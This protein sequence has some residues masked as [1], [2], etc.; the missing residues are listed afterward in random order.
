[1]EKY[2]KQT[3]VDGETPVDAEHLNHIE[4]GVERLSEAIAKN[5]THKINNNVKTV[6]HRGFNGVAPENTIPAYIMS[7][8][9][10]YDYV[11][12]D[13]AFTSDG[14]AVLLHDA[15]IDRTSNGS[16]SIAEMTYAEAAQYDYGSWKSPEFEGTHLPTFREF[17][18]LCKNL[19]LHPYIELKSDGGYTQENIT[20]IVDEVKAC[21]MVGKVTYISFNGTYLGYVKTA[22]ANA[23]LG[24]EMSAVT[25]AKLEEALT[26]KTNTNEVFIDAKYSSLTT[27][28][29][30]ACISRNLPLEVWTVNDSSWFDSMNPYISGVTTDTLNAGDI[31]YE[32]SIVYIPPEIPEVSG[33]KITLSHDEMTINSFDTQ[34]LTATVEPANASVTVE[35]TSS[36]ED[37]ATVKDGVITPNLSGETIITATVGSVSASCTV[38]VNVEDLSVPD[39]YEAVR[40]LKATDI[41]YGIGTSWKPVDSSSNPPYTVE[42]TYRAGYYMS[43]IPVEYGYAYRIDFISSHSGTMAGMQIANTKLMEYINNPSAD[44]S[45][46]TLRAN[47]ADSGWLENGAEYVIPE[48]VN[49]YP[50]E[51]M[52][53]TFKQGSSTYKGGEIK[54]VLISRKSIG[55]T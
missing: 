26:Y 14:V 8:Q 42:Q 47:L 38:T 29:V 5:E 32:N 24:Y 27:A 13:V 52:R 18:I 31:L 36:N 16:G 22:D 17:I 28:N 39:G 9:N 44:I 34:K 43:D 35:W 40:L 6:N 50:L 49:G 41:M 10:G 45:N 46:E 15:T 51:F 55:V 54:Q 1:M 19:G 7:K 4:D 21:G 2:T 53:I 20:S 3:W 30:N 33:T 12:C 37:V 11:E 25:V 48:D 23:R